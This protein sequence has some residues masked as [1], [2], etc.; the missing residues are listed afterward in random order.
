MRVLL[1]Q[2]SLYYPSHGGGD[3]SNRLLMEALAQ[4]GHECLVVARLGSSA[5][6]EHD[7]FLAELAARGVEV[8]AT[9]SGGVIFRHHGV[10]VHVVT[11]P[12]NIRGYFAGQITRFAPS[13]VL[14]STDDP[15]Q[16]LLEAAV[17]ADQPKVVYLARTTLAVPFGPDCA[18]PS[19]SKADT[20]RRVDGAVGVSEY[21]AAYLRRWGG[22]D[23]IHVPISLMEPGPYPHLGRHENEFV[24]FVNPCAVKGISIFLGLAKSMPD[25]AFAAV[26]TWGTRREDLSKLASH[27]N[28]LVLAPADDI[29]RLFSTT[30]VLLV[31]SLWAEARSRIIPEAMLRG[32][33]VLAA[34]VGGIPEAMLGMDYLLPVRP[35]RSYF[36]QVDELM[37]PIPEV[38][39]Q[40]IGPWRDA[41]RK[42]LADGAHYDQL[43]RLS[44]DRALA[45][46]ESLSILPFENYL[47]DVLRSARKPVSIQAPSSPQSVLESLSPERRR[48]LALRLRRKAAD[49]NVKDPWFPLCRSRAEAAVRLFCFPAAGGGVSAFR[50]WAEALPPEVAVC[51]ARLPGRESRLAEAPFRCMEPLVSAIGEALVPYLDRRFALFGHSMGAAVAFELTRWLRRQRRALPVALFVSGA[52]A[53]HLRLGHVPLLD[54]SEEELLNELDHL[55][56]MPPDVRGNPELLRLVMPALRADTALYR[57]YVYTEE[58]PLDLPIRAYGGRDDSNISREHLEAWAGETTGDFD[59]RTFAGGH[60]FLNT[61]RAEFLETLSK[62]LAA[63]L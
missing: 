53:P 14:T 36:H 31:P 7:R 52:R 57:S 22:L 13:A 51:A 30:R 43:S 28:V 55:E 39:E 15:A 19:P 34:D 56:K 40:D 42:L 38:P 46:T 41:L 17:R 8:G 18:F 35:I 47:E 63:I 60:F 50:Y 32:I 54:P 21:V 10:E 3:K 12:A 62:D 37:V 49:E 61:D 1:A 20:L 29:D 59:C 45:Y 4:R 58:V 27:P 2:N 11:Q 9:E 33:P 16:L 44:R 23:A 26:P 25:V 5:P 6:G 24:S 48:L